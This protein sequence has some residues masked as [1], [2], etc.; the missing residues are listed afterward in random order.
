MT[1]S[2]DFLQTVPDQ[3]DSD[4]EEQ[5]QQDSERQW[6]LKQIQMMR[7]SD[8]ELMILTLYSGLNDAELTEHLQISPENLRV[9]RYRIK[10]KL[11]TIAR[12]EQKMREERIDELFNHAEADRNDELTRKIQK[13]IRNN[14]YKRAAVVVAAA[15]LLF[16]VISYGGRAVKEKQSF[17]LSDWEAVVSEEQ[18]SKTADRYQIQNGSELKDILNAQAYISAYSSI[19]LPGIVPEF[20]EPDSLNAHAITNGTY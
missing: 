14:I 2:D 4:R 16:G 3:R 18:L 10:E 20:S 11:K 7:V 12:K 19:F 15:I 9:R 8:R 1:D 13:G 17:H 6:L 5:E